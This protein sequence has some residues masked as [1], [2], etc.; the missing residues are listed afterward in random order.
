ML[1]RTYSTAAAVAHAEF[2]MAIATWIETTY[3]QRRQQGL[4]LARRHYEVFTF[5]NSEPVQCQVM[6]YASVAP[7]A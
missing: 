5:S 6:V 4:S 7:S 3:R 2:W 1:Q